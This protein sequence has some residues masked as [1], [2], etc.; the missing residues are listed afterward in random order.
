MKVELNYQLKGFQLELMS[1][2][3]SEEDEVV[4]H[5]SQPNLMEKFLEV[6]GIKLENVDK[7]HGINKMVVVE[8]NVDYKL[9]YC[10]FSHEDELDMNLTRIITKVNGFNVE[11]RLGVYDNTIVVYHVLQSLTDLTLQSLETEFLANNV[12]LDTM[13]F[14]VPVINA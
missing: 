14:H 6:T 3:V 8:S 7:T 13:T 10:S 12:L 9:Q 1:G 4:F 11:G 2:I 5:T